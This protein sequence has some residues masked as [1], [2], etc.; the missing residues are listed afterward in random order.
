MIRISVMYPGDGSPF[1]FEYYK[2]SHM[3]LVHRLLDPY[4]LVRTEVD[5]G[6]ATNEPGKRAPYV[7]IGHLY[8]NSMDKMQEGMKAHDPELAADVVNFCTMQ[9]LFQISEI[10]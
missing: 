6:L 5:R 8:F 1:D 2:K 4:G 3:Q 7:A 9:P 10:L